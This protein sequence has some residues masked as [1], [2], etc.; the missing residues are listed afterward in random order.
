MPT[1][2][3][4]RTPWSLRS[5]TNEMPRVTAADCQKNSCRGEH[6]SPVPVCLGRNFPGKCVAAVSWRATNG[7]PYTRNK[8]GMHFFDPLRNGQDRSLQTSRKCAI[9]LLGFSTH[10][11]EGYTSSAYFPALI[12]DE[13]HSIRCN[14]HIQGEDAPFGYLRL[15]L[16]RRERRVAVYTGAYRTSG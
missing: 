7:R 11:A 15:F 12:L 2:A 8:A 9:I 5:P 6:C 3:T 16:Y 14:K 10:R 1:R 13:N 4:T